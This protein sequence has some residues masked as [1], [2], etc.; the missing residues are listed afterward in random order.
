MGSLSQH[1]FNLM[2][3]LVL[4]SQ[5]METLAALNASGD[6]CRQLSPTTLT[7]ERKVLNADL[8]TDCGAG[9]TWEH[10]GAFLATLETD[11]ISEEL[12]PTEG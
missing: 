2:T 5:E 8:L 7:D 9:Q 10:Y 3:Y 6:C 4:D 12:F 1:L 11:D